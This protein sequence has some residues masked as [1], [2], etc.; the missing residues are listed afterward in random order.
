MYF[1]CLPSAF[2]SVH[3]RKAELFQCSYV[4]PSL[5]EH[6]NDRWQ[7]PS[8]VGKLPWLP[9]N[10]KQQ[11]IEKRREGKEKKNEKQQDKKSQD[12]SS[13]K[14]S[15]DTLTVLSNTICKFLTTF[16]LEA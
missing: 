11:E 4:Q 5:F 8:S 2:L 10:N 12:C 16:V 3:H 15:T 7:Q 14:L 9:K 1:P 13:K 6:L